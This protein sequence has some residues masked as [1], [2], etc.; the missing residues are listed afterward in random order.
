MAT[1]PIDQYIQAEEAFE[2]PL[3]DCESS[4]SDSEGDHAAVEFQQPVASTFLQSHTTTLARETQ[5]SPTSLLVDTPPL[6]PSRAQKQRDRHAHR[7]RG[8]RK[9][10]AA[11]SDSGLK[12]VVKKRRTEGT[13]VAVQVPYSM[14]S[15]APVTLPGWIGKSQAQSQGGVPGKVHTKEELADHHGMKCFPWDGR[16]VARCLLLFNLTSAA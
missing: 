9:R 7:R 15:D 4:H 13:E 11:S 1:Y 16:C 6:P 8:K 10:E 14:I 12:Q 2:G 3:S 5:S